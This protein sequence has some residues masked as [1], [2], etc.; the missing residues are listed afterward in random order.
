[1]EY[2]NVLGSNGFSIQLLMSI[3]NIYSGKEHRPEVVCV[4]GM[5]K[6]QNPNIPE[7]CL[8]ICGKGTCDH[9]SKWSV[10]LFLRNFDYGA[11]HKQGPRNKFYPGGALCNKK[12][13]I[14]PIFKN[15]TS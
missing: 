6:P 12:N 2:P 4:D 3:S 15:F 7:A 13:E 1:M 11:I 8:Y 5:C 10:I 14:L 9:I